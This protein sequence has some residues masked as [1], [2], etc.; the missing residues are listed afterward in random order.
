MT[1]FRTF[2]KVYTGAAVGV[3]AVA[4]LAVFSFR[5]QAETANPTRAVA[6]LSSVQN[7]QVTGVVRFTSQGMGVRIVADVHGLPPR[8]IHGFHVHEFGDL[9]DQNSFS[10]AGGH[11]NPNAS[12][13]GGPMA[14]AHHHGDLGNLVADVSGNAHLEVDSNSMRLM[15]SNSIL[16][17]SVVIHSDPDDLTTQPSGNSGRRIAMGVIGIAQ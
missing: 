11:F 7:S 3:M 14:E 15:G 10:T 2:P 12:A 4:L 13:H 6:I 8:S 16:G 17:R 1:H 5:A 9:T